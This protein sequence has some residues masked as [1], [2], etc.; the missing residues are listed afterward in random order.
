MYKLKYI[1]ND[2]YTSD[3]VET[4]ES[5]EK[6][7]SKQK[8]S[9]PIVKSG[10]R[11]EYNRKYKARDEQSEVWD[12]TLGAFEDTFG[13]ALLL[14]SNK[15]RLRTL[16]NDIT[17]LIDYSTSTDV[18]DDAKIMQLDKVKSNPNIKS[19][20]VSKNQII[21]TK[22]DGTVIDS[23]TLSEAF[24]WLKKD[25][26]IT[27]ANRS[28]KCHEKSVELLL[29]TKDSKI[30]TG[31]IYTASTKSKYVHSWVETTIDN[32]PVVLD[33]TLNAII[34]KDGYYSL[35]EPEVVS[36]ISKQE[37]VE[38]LKSICSTKQQS[39]DLT[40]K[41]YLLFHDRVMEVYGESQN[42]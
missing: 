27:T 16:E 36:K 11:E 20:G 5:Y 38:D 12:K 29:K 21:I 13:L 26:E 7:I 18:F 41:E 1:F 17:T 32:K 35:F 2:V 14:H 24:P 37:F 3:N 31:Q 9:C 23:R 6:E 39:H 25:N 28:G 4:Y 10:I 34:N 19:V 30:V 8:S 42:N 15:T 33:Y 22:T 40:L